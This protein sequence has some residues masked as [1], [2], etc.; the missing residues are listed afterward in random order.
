MMIRK[1][2]I[3]S[4][5]GI[6]PFL[7]AVNIAVADDRV[8]A[9]GWKAGLASIII[10]PE[11]PVWMAG[12]GVRD[13]P[14]EG[15]LHDLWAK[16]LALEDAQGNLVVLVTT[17]L[18]GFPQNISNRIRDQLAIQYGLKRSQIVLSSSH[19]HGGPVLMDALF[20]IYPFGSEHIEI[21][22]RY[23]DNLE[24][25][26]VELTGK[27][28]DSMVPAKL[29]SENGVVRFQVNRRNNPVATLFRESELKGPIDHSLPV[30]KVAG[31][32][33]EVMA[34]VF[35]YACHPTTLVGYQFSGD[36]A[37]FAQIEIE[38]LH[39]GAVAMF[40]QGAGA[41]MDPVPRRTIPLARQ[42]GLELAAAVDR[43]LQE[44]MKELEPLILTAYSEVNLAFSD[45]PGREEL[46]KLKDEGTGYMQ[47]WAVSQLARLAEKKPFPAYYPYPV[48][49]WR[50]GNQPVM[51]LGGEVVVEYAIELKKLFG[52]EIFVMGYA[53]DVMSY[54]P[55][56]TVIQEGG[57]EG[58]S[59]QMVY[60]MPAAWKP[61]LQEI[62]I[63]E[64]RKLAHEIGLGQSAQ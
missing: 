48:Q 45:P 49:I 13:R 34:V 24:K 4:F 23:S 14:S 1:G 35:G 51:I 43:V 26:I 15:T 50:L 38:R 21:I 5:I 37:G 12:Y 47:R 40:F 11:E 30:L 55:S 58:A 10:T 60:G 27:A 7:I 53:N 29:F 28:I 6:L 32:S 31:A 52:Y 56:E 20:D 36:Y 18:L 39:P 59:G 22:K 57:Y 62:I 41:D 3:F 64:F 61:G 8:T 46:T 33:G 54:I 19:T 9:A 16:A 17:D 44:D 42:Y 25:Q 2:L 63:N